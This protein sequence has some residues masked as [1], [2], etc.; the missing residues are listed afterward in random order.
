MD[1]R[2]KH[3]LVGGMGL[4]IVVL[5]SMTAQDAQAVTR[6]APLSAAAAPLTSVDWANITYSSSCFSNRSVRY[7]ARN[8]QAQSNGIHFQ[9]YTPIFGDITGDGRQEAL[10]PYSCTGADFGGVHLYVYTGS[11]GQ[12]S[13]LAEIPSRSFSSSLMVSVHTITLP[14]L[15][16]LPQ[17]RVLQVEGVGYSARAIH[18]CPDLDVTLR[19][20]VTGGRLVATGTTV[21]HAAH[22]LSL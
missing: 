2:A 7:V 18:T 20:Q 6:G 19:Y 21:K 14:A 9:V 10:V 13:L 17:E 3:L 16:V 12:P 5:S 1:N 22:C 8:G 15:T 11:A 4:V